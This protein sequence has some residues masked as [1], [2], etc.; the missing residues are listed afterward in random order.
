MNKHCVACKSVITNKEVFSV[1]EIYDL[2]KCDSCGLKFI[3]PRT[4]EELEVDE[5]WDDVNEAVYQ[6]ASVIEEMYK[7]YTKIIKK[8]SPPNNKLLDVGSGAGIFLN[9]AKDAGFNIIGI[10]PSERAVEIC[11]KQFAIDANCGLLDADDSLPRDFGVISAWD[12]IEHVTD[13]LSFLNACR[14]HLIIDGLLLLE[15]PDEGCLIRKI[16]HATA[17]VTGGKMDLRPR[18]YYHHHRYYFTKK[19]MTILLQRAGFKDIEIFEG[20]TMYEKVLSKMKL[21]GVYSDIHLRFIKY[22]VHFMRLAPFAKNKM[23]VVCRRAE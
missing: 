22:I 1:S 23:I 9:I 19:S 13:P 3:Q 5:Y 16:I 2:M 7:K 15:T 21:Y 8:L 14:E 20:R 6:Q 11:N 12:V 17:K 18:I 10:E 4:G